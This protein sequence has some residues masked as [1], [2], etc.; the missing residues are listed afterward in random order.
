RYRIKPAIEQV[1]NL[2][3]IDR[4]VQESDAVERR[5]ELDVPE[6]A[7]RRM[8][9]AARRLNARP[10]RHAQLSRDKGRLRRSGRREALNHARWARDA[11]GR[12]DG[13]RPPEEGGVDR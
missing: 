8:S 3:L 12:L 6:V 10:E 13:G 9:D 7:H 4:R 11:V 2:Y 1:E 5:D